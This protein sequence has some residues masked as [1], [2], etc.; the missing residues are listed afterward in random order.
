MEKTQMVVTKR[1]AGV[2]KHNDGDF[3]VV[4]TVGIEGPEKDLLL[5]E[6]QFHREDT[7]D[8]PEEFQRRLP[9]GMWLDI[10][11]TTEITLRPERTIN[12]VLS[13]GH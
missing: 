3:S 4:Q 12:Q 9:V 13:F 11:T 7:E 2:V 5:D 1:V 6:V 10:T 8:T